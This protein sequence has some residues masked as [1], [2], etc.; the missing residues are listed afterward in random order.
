[1]YTKFIKERKQNNP[2]LAFLMNEFHC[3]MIVQER[4]ARFHEKI[5]Y[6][7]RDSNPRPSGSCLLA[8]LLT[9]IILFSKV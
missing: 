9:G 2:T 8:Y 1:M 5:F 4:F 7:Q 3:K 6:W